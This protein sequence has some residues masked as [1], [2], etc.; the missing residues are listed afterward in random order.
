[1]AGLGP[2][3]KLTF[4]GDSKDLERKLKVVEGKTS[5]FGAKLAGIGKGISMLAAG[6]GAVNMIGGAVGAITALSGAALLVPG[7]ALAGAAAMNTFKL[8]TSGFGEAVGAGLSGDVAAFTEATAKMHPEMA[9]AAKAAVAFR[10]EVD[11]LKRS[12]QGAFWDDFA[13]GV[14]GLGKNLL[15]VMRTGLTGVADQMGQV[16][17]GALQAAQTPFFTG[18][19]ASILSSTA[20][21]FREVGDGAGDVLTGIV[22]IGKV[23]ATYL[24][25]LG[26]GIGGVASRFSAWAQSLEGQNQIKAWIDRGIEAFQQLGAI[27][28]NIGSTLGSIFTG[29]GGSVDNPLQKV[30]E[31]TAKLAELAASQGAQQALTAL[32]VAAQAAGV[33]MSSTL[34]AALN[35][36][37]PVIIAAAPLVT[38]IATTM[39]TWAPVL[40]PLVVGVFGLVKAFQ[41]VQAGLALYNA[42]MLLAKTQTIATVATTVASWVAMAAGAMARAVVMAAAWVVAMG[43]VGWVIAAVVGLVALVIANWDTVK[44][45]TI[46]A[47]NAVTSG[48]AAAWGAIKGAVS[49]AASAVWSAIS[50]AWSRVT[51]VTSSAWNSIKS[52]VSSGISGMMGFITSLPGRILS[53]FGNFGSLLVNAGRSLIQGL[54]NG[55]SGIVGWIVGKVSG[56]L[57]SIRNLFPFS[58][59]KEGPFSGR[60]YTTYSGA[61]LMEDFGAGMRSAEG[62]VRSAAATVVGGASSTLADPARG[63]GGAGAGSGVVVTFR[64][65][66]SDALA[67][68]IMKLIRENKIQ[69]KAA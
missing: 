57:T 26:E 60:G 8:A 5:A 53:V 38:S 22:G 37:V 65:N 48:I 56:V 28:G 59:A 13:D 69:I 31:F 14:T 51:S 17:Y 33:L 46:A 39:A 19:T 62:D 24:P 40:G 66:T 10:P 32:G 34:L 52:A 47:W 68:V 1:M 6:G 25:Q 44:S 9:A 41:A 54:W 7:A 20:G 21:F 27:A 2:T 64:G 30:V 67:T 11:A 29:L 49:S 15:P 58:P 23:G 35:A 42:A 43:P 4:A 36:L 55:I 12:V 18:A 50:G 45:A 3:V 16:T 61:A 63:S